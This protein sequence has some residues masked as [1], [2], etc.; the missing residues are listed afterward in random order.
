MLNSRFVLEI[1]IAQNIK[2]SRTSTIAI[3]L[4]F[5]TEVRISPS[6]TGKARDI[7]TDTILIY[8]ELLFT[9]VLRLIG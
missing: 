1:N 6:F 8:T 2:S 9:K 3:S 7:A 5:T 4:T